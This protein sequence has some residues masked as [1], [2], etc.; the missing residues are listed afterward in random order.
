[1][2]VE[3]LIYLSITFCVILIFAYLSVSKFIEDLRDSLQYTLDVKHFI[4]CSELFDLKEEIESIESV[5]KYLG[6]NLRDLLAIYQK[7]IS[8]DRLSFIKISDDERKSIAD[9]VSSLMKNGSDR[10]KDVLKCYMK[11]QII[12][13]IYKEVEESS[14]F[15]LLKAYIITNTNLTKIINNKIADNAEDIK[16]GKP[17][18]AEL[19][20]CC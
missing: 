12:L 5:D 15:N 10:Q 20:L 14:R 11:A 18:N 19:D 3:V 7:N 9:T 8:L 16:T 1:M 13:T 4:N 17:Y 2:G 6:E